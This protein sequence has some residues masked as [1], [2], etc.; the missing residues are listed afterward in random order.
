MKGKIAFGVISITGLVTLLIL[1]T[2]SSEVWDGACGHKEEFG[3]FPFYR[4]GSDAIPV[5]E[6][7]SGVLFPGVLL[8]LAA[9]AGVFVGLY[10]CWRKLVKKS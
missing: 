6:C 9:T 5:S 7:A 4:A 8:T 10:L 3:L 2:V 1:F